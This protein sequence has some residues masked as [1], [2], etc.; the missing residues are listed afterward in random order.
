M[1][2]SRA[3]ADPKL[4]EAE[5]D[6]HSLSDNLHSL[7]NKADDATKPNSE[8]KREPSHTKPKENDASSE[9]LNDD[10]ENSLL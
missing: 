1:L 2:I 7:R 5:H 3:A 8:P 9:Q 10:G 6:G 4:L